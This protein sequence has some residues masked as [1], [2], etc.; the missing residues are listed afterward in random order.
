MSACQNAIIVHYYFD[1]SE[2]SRLVDILRYES[3]Y[4]TSPTGY[5]LEM[6][7]KFDLDYTNQITKLIAQFVWQFVLDE[8]ELPA[9][10]DGLIV[11]NP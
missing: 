3:P 4:G 5:L 1:S 10:A 9:Q 7:C 8:R 11:L 6:L 2:I